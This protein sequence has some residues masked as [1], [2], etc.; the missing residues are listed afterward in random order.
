M[1]TKIYKMKKLFLGVAMLMA[2]VGSKAQTAEEIVSK[3]IEALG[4]KANIEKVKAVAMEGAMEVQGASVTVKVTK[5][6]G[7]LSRQDIS[8]MGM[9]GYDL[10]TDTSGWM[11]MPFAGQTEPTAKSGDVLKMAQMD[12]GIADNLYDY[13]AKGN[14]IESLGKE[15]VS[16]VD[17]Y[18]LKYTTASTGDTAIV[19]LNPTDWM[20]SRLST[21]KNVNG[22]DFPVTIDFSDYKDTDGMKFPY[23]M[24][25]MQGTIT[26]S[27]IKVNPTID[28]KLY[29]K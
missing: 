9:T 18:K 20:I 22:Q 3:H 8:V 16:G 1:A 26:F 7:K 6:A 24:S 23:T 29:K 19:Y 10:T 25:T 21:V 12:M 17:C 13:K 4:G 5:V 27:S 11:F 2:V 28:E 15:D 14:K